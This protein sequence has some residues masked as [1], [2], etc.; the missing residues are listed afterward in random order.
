MKT[1]IFDV[2]SIKKFNDE[3]RHQETIWSDD[4]SR[5]SL[6]C[7][8]AGQEIVTHTHHG[9][10]I[11]MVVEGTGEF[12][13]GGQKRTIGVGQIV[14]VPALEEHGIRN[15]SGGDLVIASITAA[16]D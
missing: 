5:V 11:W 4:H 1:Q 14:I 13:S 6:L 7:M 9:S 10:H 16:G 3:K 2:H 15:V 8:K 12:A